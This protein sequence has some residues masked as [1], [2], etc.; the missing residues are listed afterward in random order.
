MRINV[1]AEG[2]ANVGRKPPFA[3]RYEPTVMRQFCERHLKR[4]MPA[5]QPYVRSMLAKRTGKTPSSSTWRCHFMIVV[6]EQTF[7]LPAEY[8]GTLRWL[9]Q[10]HQLLMEVMKAIDRF[11]SAK[12]AVQP[13]ITKAILVGQAAVVLPG[14]DPAEISKRYELHQLMVLLLWPFSRYVHTIRSTA[15]LRKGRIYWRTRL[16]FQVGDL[17]FS[18]AAG[19]IGTDNW[20]YRLMGIFRIETLPADLNEA[21]KKAYKELEMVATRLLNK[22]AWL[23]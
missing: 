17:E 22:P 12:G 21:Q 7:K 13:S 23:G 16:H 5:F 10:H 9:D 14:M 3:E 8:A 18:A 1:R 15:G 4:L 2:W 19:G 6:G 11:E 20:V